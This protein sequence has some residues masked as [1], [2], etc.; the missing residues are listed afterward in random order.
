MNSASLLL[1]VWAAPAATNELWVSYNTR[2]WNAGANRYSLVEDFISNEVDG[3]AR[4]L[5][6]GSGN[7]GCRAGAYGPYKYGSGWQV[8]FG[9]NDCGTS[10]LNHYAFYGNRGAADTLMDQLD[11][12]AQSAISG[13]L[14]TYG[15][16]IGTKTEYASGG[17]IP[18]DA[19]AK[20]CNGDIK[21][22]WTYRGIGVGKLDDMAIPD[23]WE[24]ACQSDEGLSEGVIAA[25][26]GGVVGGLIFIGVVAT[27]IFC[28]SVC[29]GS[30]GPP[31]PPPPPPQPV[32][33]PAAPQMQM[34]VAVTQPVV[35][36]VAPAVVAA[37]PAAPPGAKFDPNTG[38][39]ILPFGTKFDPNTGAPISKF[40]PE[41]GKQNW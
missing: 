5:T 14:Y 2:C 4:V 8:Y 33:Q 29:K 38:K 30:G 1:V 24:R 26:V 17:C 36:P 25:I 16:I 27:V 28:S 21:H 35:V 37:P 34:G 32:G 10:G 39:P 40:D 18:Y 3:S 20:L 7:T 41:T 23:S 31:A 6:W 13:I 22:S 9:W 12:A 15:E 11:G 19:G